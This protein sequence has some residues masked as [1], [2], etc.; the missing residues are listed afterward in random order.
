MYC[1]CCG[2]PVNE[3]AI[4]CTNCGMAPLSERK[5]CQECGVET[6]E[7]QIVCI[8]C[9]VSLEVKGNNSVG[10]KITDDFYCSSDDKI[11]M[12]V[13]GGL[14]HKYK[15][16]PWIFRLIFLFGCAAIVALPVYFI[17]GSKPKI[18]TKN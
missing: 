8:K 15:L 2:K 4:A 6:K 16:S 17:L 13:C 3:K 5:F 9:G 7:N 11:I 10:N 12:G 14:G 18:S 1:K